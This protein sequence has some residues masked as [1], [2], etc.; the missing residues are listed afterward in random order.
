MPDES[1]FDEDEPA[2]QQAQDRIEAMRDEPL[3][4]TGRPPS[5]ESLEAAKN[6]VGEIPEEALVASLKAR[7]LMKASDLL[8]P[9]HEESPEDYGFEPDNKYMG[10][11]IVG[12]DRWPDVPK[13]QVFKQRFYVESNRGTVG[14]VPW[15]GSQVVWPWEVAWTV[16]L[17][18]DTVTSLLKPEKEAKKR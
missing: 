5:E 18:R 4:T 10:F 11:Q 15:P 14:L 12:E 17:Y 16:D 13:H 6:L 7:G 3:E 2:V 1:I 8:D 9:G